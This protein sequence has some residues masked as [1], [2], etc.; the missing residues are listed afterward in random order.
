MLGFVLLS[1]NEW[2]GLD[3]VAKY[4]GCFDI[5]IIWDLNSIKCNT[6]MYLNLIEKPKIFHQPKPLLWM[7]I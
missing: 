7:L 2:R 1:G 5:S 3:V 6:T 4:L